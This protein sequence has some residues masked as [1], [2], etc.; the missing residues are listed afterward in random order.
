[1]CLVLLWDFLDIICIEFLCKTGI[2]ANTLMQIICC[3]VFV[4]TGR[5]DRFG[6][7]SGQGVFTM[8][9]VFGPYLKISVSMCFCIYFDFVSWLCAY[10]FTWFIFVKILVASKFPKHIILHFEKV[11]IFRHF[12]QFQNLFNYAI[13]N[14]ETIFENLKP[15]TLFFVYH[16]FFQKGRL[17]YFW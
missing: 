12:T 17:N 9:F 4:M 15:P 14:F 8:N 7:T 11:S 2:L 13:W 3:P 6:K 16:L 10:M 5:S 1:M